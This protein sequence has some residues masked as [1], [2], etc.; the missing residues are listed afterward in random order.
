LQ[1]I[2]LSTIDRYQYLGDLALWL[3]NGEINRQA[4]MVAYIDDFWA[5]MWF[6][7]AAAPLAFLMSRSDPAMQA[8]L[9]PLEA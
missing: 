4:A 6:T 1:T 9:E 5:M 3:I 8:E 2:D 7:L